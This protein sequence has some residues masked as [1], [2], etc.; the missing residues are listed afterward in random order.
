MQKDGDL[1]IT[2]AAF[3]AISSMIQEVL[4]GPTGILLHDIS[5]PSTQNVLQ[6]MIMVQ[7][8][9]LLPMWLVIVFRWMS[10]I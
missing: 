9:M 8:G 6:F 7:E 4:F 3:L 5:S 10:V 2:A 1:D